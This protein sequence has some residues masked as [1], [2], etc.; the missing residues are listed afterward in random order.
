LLAVRVTASSSVGVATTWKA[1]VL[2]TVTDLLPTGFRIGGVGSGGPE[3]S[4]VCAPK[5]SKVSLA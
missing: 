5:P 2:L 3:Q 1:S 4:L